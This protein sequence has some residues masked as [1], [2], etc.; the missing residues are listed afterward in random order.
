MTIS[1][2]NTTSTGSTFVPYKKPTPELASS[3]KPTHPGQLKVVLEKGKGD[4]G[5]DTYS[6]YLIAEQVRTKLVYLGCAMI[7]ASA[8]SILVVN[9]TSL[10][11]RPS[12]SYGISRPESRRTRVYNMAL[13]LTTT[14]SSTP[15]CSSVRHLPTLIFPSRPSSS[16]P[17]AFPQSTTLAPP[18]YSSTSPNDPTDRAQNLLP[19]F[20]QAGS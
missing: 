18:T 17:V 20:P 19:T 1:L 13:G 10:P 16:H 14:L 3:Y 4:D 9:R 8:D 5:E 2:Q 12:A 7:R 6:S 15:T 11:T